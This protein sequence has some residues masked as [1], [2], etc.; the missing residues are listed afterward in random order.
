MASD[1]DVSF[2]ALMESRIL[3]GLMFHYAIRRLLWLVPTILAMALVTFTIMHATPGSP[4]D[5]F[6]EGANPLARLWT[7]RSGPLQPVH[8]PETIATAIRIGNPRSWKKALQALELTDGLVIDVTDREI[9]EA[10]AVIGRDGIG[11]EPASATTLAGIRKLRQ[12]G[13]IAEDATFVAVLTGHALKDT[14]Y[15]LKSEAK[16]ATREA[17]VHAS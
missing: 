6:A 14:E 15:I 7:S 13:S 4:L 3:P 16:L 9:G 17:G 5:P 12:T 11:C 2:G 1:I 8:N 10:K